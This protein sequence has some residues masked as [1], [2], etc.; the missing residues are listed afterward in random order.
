MTDESRE[1]DRAEVNQRHT[2]AAAE[3]AEDRVRA[4][5]AQV[6]PDRQLQPA[7]DGEALDRGDDRLGQPQPCRS[8]RPDAVHGDA[9][10]LA[11]G[12]GLQVGAGAE[13]AGLAGQDRDV[14]VRVG[15]EGLEG[16]GQRN[17][18]RFVDGVAD[19]ARRGYACAAVSAVCSA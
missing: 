14:Q 15:I 6:A 12:D 5:D 11:G 4:R 17:R 1:P 18:G 8:H 2:E 7:G 19:R 13:V 10:L 9:L 3:D 16:V